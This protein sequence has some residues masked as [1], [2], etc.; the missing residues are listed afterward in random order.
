MNE[1]ENRDATDEEHARR[2]QDWWNKSELF[3]ELQSATGRFLTEFATF[4]A[5]NLTSLLMA[6]SFDQPLIE[7]LTDLM[8]IERK[9]LLLERLV[10]ERPRNP[11]V[12]G[13][14]AELL[15][16]ARNLK[17]KRNEIAHGM[18]AVALAALDPQR[19]GKYVTGIQ[20]PKH[21]LPVP[22]PDGFRSQ[23]Q[24]DQ[25]LR[26]RVHTTQQID[27]YYERTVSLNHNAWI[28]GATLRATRGSPQA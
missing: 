20:R 26:Q 6:L 18:A 19:P 8:E 5:L 3:R 12:T 13:K 7:N 1:E 10:K 22:P 16:E 25:H 27:E 21:R 11:D 2:F 17:S 15:E 4:E 23:A 9:F 28:I 24:F 14:I